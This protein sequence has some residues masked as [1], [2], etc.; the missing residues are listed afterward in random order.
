M[1]ILIPDIIKVKGNKFKITMRFKRVFKA[2]TVLEK[3]R[4][5]LKEKN[6]IIVINT[7]NFL[8]YTIVICY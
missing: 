3:F 1:S 5:R 2:K 8:L 7:S 4:L 6:H